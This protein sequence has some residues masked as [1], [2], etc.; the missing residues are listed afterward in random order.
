MT[1]LLCHNPSMEKGVQTDDGVFVAREWA[2]R[3]NLC[4]PLF[5]V[6]L[7]RFILL[8]L[9]NHNPLLR[10]FISWQLVEALYRFV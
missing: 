7:R 2:A 10:Y 4:W 6:L 3:L 8:F 9:V 5:C 1:G